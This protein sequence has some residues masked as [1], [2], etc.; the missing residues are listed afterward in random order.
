MEKEN[1]VVEKEVQESTTPTVEIN[2]D[3]LAKFNETHVSKEEYEKV[4]KEKND[5]VTAILDGTYSKKE[6]NTET[7]VDI[8]QATKDLYSNPD[9]QFK[10]VEYVTKVLDL[11]DA[12]IHRDG[13]ENDPFLPFGHDV[14]ITDY[15][16]E[17]A[18]NLAKVLRDC[19]NESQGDNDLFLA[20]LQS[21]TKESLPQAKITALMKQ[22]LLK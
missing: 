13:I 6:G 18:Q 19:V 20:L 1:E 9:K 12:V 7:Y 10:D 11:R 14:K 15:D 16:R 21:K 2:A 5:I 8:D 22:G 17:R 3:D 4:V